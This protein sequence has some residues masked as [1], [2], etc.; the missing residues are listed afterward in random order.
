MS[1]SVRLFSFMFFIMLLTPFAFAA[2]D[3][4]SGNSNGGS[5]SGSSNGSNYQNNS[6]QN[7]DAKV[8]TCK[9]GYVYSNSKKACV[10]MGSEI[11]PD[12]DL[13]KQGH[14]LALKGEYG[15]A[16]DILSAIK[17]TDDPMVYTM[18]GFTTRKLGRWDEGMAIYKK[19][20]ALD[21]TNPNTHEYIGE[22]YIAVGRYDLAQLQLKE[23]EIGCGNRDCY[24]YQKLSE[25]IESGIIQ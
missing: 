24:Q 14:A 9:K 3:G 10:K 16:L 20:L 21:P 11:V 6:D 15:N 8:P 2:G 7:E 13:Y 4:G 1:K 12:N 19:A 17:K 22:A 5:T 18:L 25:A 23:V